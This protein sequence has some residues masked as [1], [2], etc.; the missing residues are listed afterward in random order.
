MIENEMERFREHEKEFKMKQ[1]SKRA[2]A[3]N[4]E[5]MG[6]FVEGDDDSDGSHSYGFEDSDGSRD[7]DS[8]AEPDEGEFEHKESGD[9]S[10]YAEGD[11][12]A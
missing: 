7:S 2:L 11:Q 4:L 3:A 12:L 1:Y 5:H 9:Y 6:N 10:E 8:G